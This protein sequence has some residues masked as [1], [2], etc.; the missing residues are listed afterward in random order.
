MPCPVPNRPGP[1]PLPPKA[2]SCQVTRKGVGAQDSG[3][4]NV[5][6]AR[7]TRRHVERSVEML[8]VGGSEIPLSSEVVVDGG[9]IE[10]VFRSGRLERVDQG[11][12]KCGGMNVPGLVGRKGQVAGSIGAVPDGD[13]VQ[14][15]LSDRLRRLQQPY[16]LQVGADLK[17]PRSGQGEVGLSPSGAAVHCEAPVGGGQD[18]PG[19]LGQPFRGIQDPKL[20]GSLTAHRPLSSLRRGG[21]L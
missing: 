12:V 18:L 13:V 1:L 11:S 7:V 6:E 19:F 4:Q 10:V 2:R 9:M 16:G 3:R 20:H 14:I 17:N 21:T 15:H 5:V 8:H